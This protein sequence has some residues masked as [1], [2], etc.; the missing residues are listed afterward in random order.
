MLKRHLSLFLPVAA[1]LLMPLAWAGDSVDHDVHAL[2]LEWARIKYQLPEDQQEKAFAALAGRAHALSTANAAKAEPKIWEA[3]IKSTYAGAKGGLG[4][5]SLMKEARDLM[6]EAEKINPTALNGS[7]YTSLGSFYYMTPGWPL[8]FGDDDQAREYLEKALSIA[9]D[10]MDSN[11]FMGDF[12]ME[13]HKYK[14]AIPYLQK[15]VDLPAVEDRPVYSEGRKA[16]AQALLD[17]ARK[18]AH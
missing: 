11:F 9:P 2:Q 10:D 14:K 18:K 3:I 6:L 13:K 8:G 17:K 5:L 4:A 15:V 12:W 7:I 1:L 16:E